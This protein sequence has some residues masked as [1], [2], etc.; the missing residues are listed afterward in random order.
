MSGTISASPNPCNVSTGAL[1]PLGVLLP[2]PRDTWSPLAKREATGA[3]TT[4]PIPADGT[5]VTVLSEQERGNHALT[6]HDPSHS[7]TMTSIPLQQQG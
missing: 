6:Q 3:L 4:A 7:T 1:D 2:C 5:D